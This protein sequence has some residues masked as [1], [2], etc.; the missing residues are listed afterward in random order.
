MNP[1]DQFREC[2]RNADRLDDHG[3]YN[4][5]LGQMNPQIYREFFCYVGD[6]E[7][8]TSVWEP[9]SGPDGRGFDCTDDTGVALE[10]HSMRSNH[11]Y[12]REVDSTKEGPPSWACPLDGVILHPPYYG[13]GPMSD[14]PND[15]SWVIDID[16]YR[17][18]L[19]SVASIIL[20]NISKE[21]IVCAVGRRYR[22][23][24]KEIKLDEWFVEAFCGPMRVQEVWIS[25]PDVVIL[26]GF[27]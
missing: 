20:E 4:L 25:E 1:I 7:T 2:R 9:F 15:M 27:R 23:A 22:Y 6:G 8:Q 18:K 24:G 17:A 14:C 5:A 11:G 19:A 13:S 16:E 12:V 10:A 3:D 26:M 21:G